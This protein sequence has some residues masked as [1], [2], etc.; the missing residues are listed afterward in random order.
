MYP[1]TK[2]GSPPT[3]FWWRPARP[4]GKRRHPRSWFLPKS[5]DGGLDCLSPS[6]C[7]IS[8]GVCLFV[9]VPFFVM[10]DDSAIRFTSSLALPTFSRTAPADA[11]DHAFGLFFLVAGQRA[12][13][14]FGPALEV[15]PAFRR[16]SS[17]SCRASSRE[18]MDVPAQEYP[19]HLQARAQGRPSEAPGRAQPV[20]SQ[21]SAEER[22]FSR[23]QTA[24]GNHLRPQGA[25]GSGR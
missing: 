5:S 4:P 16:V 1:P 14:L 25:R 2:S 18:N 6:S 13:R 12:R 24:D 22:S 20:T 8:R 11:L 15:T 10:G 21:P 19:P 23:R 9:V 17:C 3:A 7:R